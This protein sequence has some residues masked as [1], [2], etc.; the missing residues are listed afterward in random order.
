MHHS[1]F[2]QPESTSA[3]RIRPQAWPN[4]RKSLKEILSEKDYRRVLGALANASGW[5]GIRA[6]HD[7]S[8]SAYSTVQIGA[9]EMNALISGEIDAAKD[10]D[11]IRAKGGG[12]KSLV[13]QYPEMP[14]V[15]EEII[16]STTY[17]N[18]E[19]PLKWTTLSLIKISDQLKERGIPA[20]KNVVAKMLTELGY[21]RQ[22]NQK[23]LQVGKPHP[24]RD[25]Q[26]R[27][28]N[29]AVEEYTEAGLPATSID[30]KKKELL[31][32]FMNS[33]T[34][35]RRTKDPRLVLDHDFELKDLGHIAPFG[36]YDLNKNTAFI[37]LGTSRDTAEFSVNSLYQWW[38]HFGRPTYPD[39]E[40]ILVTCDGGGS[41]SSHARLWKA[42]L[43]AFAQ[44]TGVSVQVAHF[45][46]GT[47]KWNKIEHRVFCFIT[48]NWQGRPLVDIETAVYLIGSTKNSSGL[49]VNVQI[50]SNIYPTGIK[51]SDDEFDD[52]DIERLDP[53]PEWNYIIHGFKSDRHRPL[54]ATLRSPNSEAQ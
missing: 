29:A 43:A 33:G 36:V 35:Y 16:E 12:R 1:R 53:Y 42:E 4:S 32:N 14:H 7:A 2:S 11:R 6:V 20:G 10:A 40:R 38:L 34:E 31:G 5:G 49:K 23:Q 37:N 50:D 8:G 9:H 21:S 19:D 28:I 44:T 30:A 24:D 45:P 13:E 26:F 48:K 47:S 15:I 54:G 27:F 22:Q 51:V 18:P 3:R 25:G 52:I 17:G 39:A 41:N 46:P